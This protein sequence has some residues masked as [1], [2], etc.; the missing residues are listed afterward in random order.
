VVM[1]PACGP[2]PPGHVRC[3]AETITPR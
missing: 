1:T 2:A 3:F